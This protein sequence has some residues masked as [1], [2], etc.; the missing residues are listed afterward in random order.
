MALWVKRYLHSLPHNGHLINIY[1]S[2]VPC[3]DDC[4]SIITTE[5][6]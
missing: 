1:T 6:C 2:T 5:C 3:R 4:F